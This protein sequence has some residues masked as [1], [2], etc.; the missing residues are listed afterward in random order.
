MLSNP[1]VGNP[2]DRFFGDGARNNIVFVT[3]YIN[4]YS[5][6]SIPLFPVTILLC[7]LIYRGYSNFLL[8]MALFHRVKWKIFI[9]HE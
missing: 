8:N 1:V 2:G 3:L 5:D 9:F 6:D 7:R 4:L